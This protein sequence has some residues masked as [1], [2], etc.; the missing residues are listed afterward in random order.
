MDVCESMSNFRKLFVR[1]LTRSISKEYYR[2]KI[3]DNPYSR[4]HIALEFKDDLVVGSAS[5]TPK[6][7][8]ILGTE[9]LGAEIGDTFTHPDYRRIGVF[10]RVVKECTEYAKSAGIH[11]IYGTPNSES[12]PGYQNKLEFPPCLHTKI[13][14]MYKYVRVDSLQK[15][16]KR[17]LKIGFIAGVLSRVYFS[18]LTLLSSIKNRNKTLKPLTIETQPILKF[19]KIIDGLW[20]TKREDYVFFSVRDADYF[21]W[22][23][24]ANPDEYV[25]L[26]AKANNEYV[27]CIVLKLSRNEEICIGSICD[28]ITYEDNIDIFS[29]LLSIAE[30]VLYD[31]GA[32]RIELHCAIASPYY[33]PICNYGYLTREDKPIIVYSGTD[34]GKQVLKSSLKWQFTLA[35]SDN[36]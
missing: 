31:A 25:I 36:I 17:R 1:N 26:G 27:G 15:A 10:S 13:K 34:M 4:G 9:V 18:Y 8:N 3:L 11:L 30:K 6:K 20:G 16:A 14:H 28:F 22:R 33:K 35:D 12:L 24:L 23:F 29:H 21:H 5:I 2:W 32:H 19:E 7:L